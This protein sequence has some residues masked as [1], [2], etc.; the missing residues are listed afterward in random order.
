MPLIHS[1]DDGLG[2]LALQERIIFLERRVE[3]LERQYPSQVE[4][5]EGVRYVTG[6][7][8]NYEYHIGWGIPPYKR[9][10][11]IDSDLPYRPFRA[12]KLFS[13]EQL[14]HAFTT[15]GDLKYMPLSIS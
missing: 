9:W 4:S 8:H 13:V 1:Q 11:H 3:L 15:W 2:L 6:H 14:Y 7:L 12:P 5:T 10:T